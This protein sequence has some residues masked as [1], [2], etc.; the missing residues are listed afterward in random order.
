MNNNELKY[1][2]VSNRTV[3]FMPCVN[4]E[5]SHY[6]K[7]VHILQEQCEKEHNRMHPRTIIRTGLFKKSE[8]YR[9]LTLTES[10]EAVVDWFETLYDSSTGHK[11]TEDQRLILPRA[12]I[13]TDTGVVRKGNSTKFKIISESKQLITLEESFAE[14]DISIN[15]RRTD[16]IEL[17]LRMGY[18]KQV[19][20]DKLV[21]LLTPI[22]EGKRALAKAYSSVVSI[23]IKKNGNGEQAGVYVPRL[24]NG[25]ALLSMYIKSLNNIPSVCVKPVLDHECSFLRVIPVKKPTEQ[26]M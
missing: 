17:D 8:V 2:T 16:G 13:D 23:I 6:A 21:D 11:R 12:C 22:F 25:T 15:Y 18:N 3:T 14:K 10:V 5:S 1:D 19:P 7:A 20:E 4:N 26:E 24:T 9:P